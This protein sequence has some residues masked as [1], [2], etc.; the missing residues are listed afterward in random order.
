MDTPSSLERAS[1]FEVSYQLSAYS[2][3]FSTFNFNTAGWRPRPALYSFCLPKK[4]KQ[5]KGTPAPGPPAAG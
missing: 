1:G 4:S 3:Q 5:K 2:F